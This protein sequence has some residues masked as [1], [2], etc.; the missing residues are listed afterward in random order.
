MKLRMLVLAPLAF[1]ALF[2]AARQE[3]LAFVPSCTEEVAANYAPILRA[4]LS[5]CRVPAEPKPEP[6]LDLG[7]FADHL[8]GTWELQSRTVQGITI[9]GKSRML[10]DIGKVSPTGATGSVAALDC[11]DRTCERTRLSGSWS[12]AL[13][14]TGDR[15]ALTTTAQDPQPRGKT[16]QTAPGGA[17]SLALASTGDRIALTTTAQDPQPRGKTA[18][19]APVRQVTRSKFFLQSGVFVAIDEMP[20][21]KL[22]E[23]RKWDRIVLTD[24]TLTYISCRE[25]RVDRYLK[26]SRSV[27]ARGTPAQDVMKQASLLKH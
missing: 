22:D 10:V 23:E 12:L 3:A 27:I 11:V 2:T 19:T 21:S 1:A 8:G 25:M 7:S 20:G 17:W 14:S 13:A 5:A 15:I 9:Q 18:Q 24:K 4:D 16:A 6:Q 26:V